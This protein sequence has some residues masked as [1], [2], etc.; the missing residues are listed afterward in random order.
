MQL[1]KCSILI[2]F[3]VVSNAYS[4]NFEDK[5]DNNDKNHTFYYTTTREGTCIKIYYTGEAFYKVYC[6][7]HLKTH[8]DTLGIITSKNDTILYK[9]Y[10]RHSECFD[11]YKSKSKD[12]TSICLN[13]TKNNCIDD[14]T[15]E[16]RRSVKKIQEIPCKINQ[17]FTFLAFHLG[18]LNAIF[19]CVTYS[20]ETPNLSMS[21]DKD[22]SIR[23][24]YCFNRKI[25]PEGSKNDKL[26]DTGL[27][28][29]DKFL[30]P[31]GTSLL[32]GS[33]TP[34]PSTS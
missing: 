5:N 13:V 3:Y 19:R 21:A 25:V 14:V 24:R 23:V 4:Q 9:G 11:I 31:K 18:K 33:T 29:L 16:P 12:K 7:E 34:A 20:L 28:I 17:N 8:N 10:G 26:W 32:N 1:F 27:K 22:D 15:D 6:F 30:K 2:L